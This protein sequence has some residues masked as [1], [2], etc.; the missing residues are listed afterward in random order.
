MLGEFQYARYP[1]EKWR[2]ALLK[3]KSGGLDTI[4]TTV[5][6][7]FHEEERGKFDWTGRRSLREFL[8]RCQEADLHVI[9][10]IQPGH[11]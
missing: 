8:Q 6:W 3:M 4:S 2:D 5:F 7:M 1:H 11:G 10:R 9:V